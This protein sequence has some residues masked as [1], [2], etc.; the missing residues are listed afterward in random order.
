MSISL[1]TAKKLNWL[2]KDENKIEWIQSMIKIADK[3]A[4]IVPFI[5]TDEQ[6]NLVEGLGHLKSLSSKVCKLF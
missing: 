3:E 5:L 6:R 1:E 2:W 4:N